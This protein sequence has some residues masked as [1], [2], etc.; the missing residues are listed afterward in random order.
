MENYS[1][2]TRDKTFQKK[3]FKYVVSSTLLILVIYGAIF[4]AQNYFAGNTPSGS[5]G[6]SYASVDSGINAWSQLLEKSNIKVTRDKDTITLPTLGNI[7]KYS[8]KS[9]ILDLSRETS[10]IIVINGSLPDS[11]IEQVEKFVEAGGRLITDNPD[12][13]YSIFGDS[14]EISE[15]GSKDQIIAQSNVNGID[16]IEEIEGSGIGEIAFSSKLNAEKLLIP[17]SNN[18]IESSL[19]FGEYNTSVIIQLKKGD[20]I[21]VMDA[22]IVSNAGLARKDN[23]LF[24]IRIAGGENSEVTFA[25]GIHGYSN[26]KGFYAFPLAWRISIIGLVAAFIIFGTAKAR[27]FGVGE[28]SPRSLGPKRIQYA[29]ALA[30]AMKKSKK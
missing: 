27:R 4:I 11:E 30:H 6:S 9:D 15:Q 12:I 16:G 18:N 23:A 10:S 14:I 13:L 28:E 24:S 17:N 29:R 2:L 21:A 3:T 25:E 8:S 20:V 7:D 22:G 19:N 1:T 5:P 26:K